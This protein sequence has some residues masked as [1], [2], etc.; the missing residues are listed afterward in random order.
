MF[1]NFDQNQGQPTEW[2]AA[3]GGPLANM[4]SQVAQVLNGNGN[5]NRIYI[6]PGPN[7]PIFQVPSFRVALRD[8]FGVFRRSR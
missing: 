3:P 1:G 7:E 8:F 4:Q 6:A 2:N 5:G